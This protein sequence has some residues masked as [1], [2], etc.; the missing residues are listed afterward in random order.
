MTDNNYFLTVTLDR[1]EGKEAILIADS[2]EKF[3]W[4]IKN[5]PTDS[6]EGD[7]LRLVLFNTASEKEERE[8]IAKTLLN[9]ILKGE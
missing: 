3:N 8:K 7:Q 5:L 1:F 4:P 6:K 9:E 2:G